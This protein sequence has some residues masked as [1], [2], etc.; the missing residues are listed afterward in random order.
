M[1]YSISLRVTRAM[2]SF[3]AR[4]RGKAVPS[5][6]DRLIQRFFR[7]LAR[8]PGALRLQDDAALVVPPMGSE[9]VIKT[10]AIIEGV[11]FFAEDPADSIARKALRVNLSDLA[12]KGAD[13]LGF[14]LTLALPGDVEDQWIQSFADG[15]DA[16][17]EA[18]NC[19]LLGGDTDR[20]P[21]LL[22]VSV[23]ALGHVPKGRMVLRSGA[24]PDE[25]IVVTG[26]I[27]DAALGLWFRREPE[28]AQKMGLSAGER[29]HLINRYLLPEPRNALAS[30]LREFAS[31]AM[32]ISDGLAGD[33]AKLAAAS[34]VSA[35]V[36]VV[37]LPLSRGA[38]RMIAAEPR[39]IETLCTGGDDYEIIATVPKAALPKLRA[40]ATGVGIALT[41]IG[42]IATGEGSDILGS[43]GQPLRFERLSYSHF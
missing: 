31:A 1:P 9:I 33:L 18:Y 42:V 30:A 10:D 14:V 21:G 20:T 37:R 2:P 15:L 11:H 36:D 5:G 12:A 41:E 34:E 17:S 7:P 22:S 4:P 32:D 19:P 23:T 24:R 13:P 39:L 43:K 38:Q 29:A 25:V 6:E 40:A 27:G 28:R 3:P 16:D 35:K 8:H 26:T